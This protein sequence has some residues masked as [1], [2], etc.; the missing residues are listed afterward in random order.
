MQV[1]HN[2]M[3]VVV[4]GRKALFLRNEGDVDAPNLV[5]ENAREQK[6]P[7]DHEQARD[8]SGTAR[9]TQ[10]GPGA[11]SVARNGSMHAR[12]GGAQF[13]PARGT[14]E[15]TDLHQQAEDR[16]AQETADMLKDRAMAKDFEKLIIIAPPKTL[17][18]LRKCYHKEVQ[19]RVTAELAK[20]LTGHSIPDIEAALLKA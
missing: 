10:S 20:D 5:V 8:A 7:A 1:P 2:T 18:E 13:A 3:V 9:S 19:T 15:E 14:F 17:G 4:D 6:N 12:G 16:F 11:P